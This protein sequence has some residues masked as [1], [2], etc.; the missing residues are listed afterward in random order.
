MPTVHILAPDVAE[1]AGGVRMLYRHVDVLNAAG[2]PAAIVHYKP[3]FRV[4]WFEHRTIVRHLPVDLKSDDVVV[5]PEVEGPAIGQ[6]VPGIRK[7]IFNQNAYYTFA[8]YPLE[9]SSVTAPYLHP[10]VVATIVVSED[11]RRYLRHAFPSARIHRVR[12]G[13]DPE[14]YH[15]GAAKQ[16][17]IAFMP[18]KHPEDAQQVIN[19][20]RFR[21]VLSGWRVAPIQNASQTQAAAILR[22]SMIFLSFGHP[23]G[24]GLPAAEAMACGCITIG[25][26]G[27]GGREFWDPQFSFPIAA[28]DVVGFAQAAEGV[29]RALER[30]PQALAAKTARAARFIRETYSPQNEQQDIISTWRQILTEGLA[31]GRSSLAG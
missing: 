3:G 6:A 30:T 10:E 28:G 2:I 9:V 8:H 14:L 26:H 27:N 23:E 17:Q 15:A 16:K 11:S 25:Y 18:R 22:E 5:F 7:V 13:I 12:L 29:L 21:E 19:L 24:F 4:D 31:D 20:L 1:P